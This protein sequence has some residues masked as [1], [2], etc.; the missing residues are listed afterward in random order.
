[1][2]PHVLV[3]LPILGIAD[4]LLLR[5]R[6]GWLFWIR[7]CVFEVGT[8]FGAEGLTRVVCDPSPTQVNSALGT[9]LH[10]TDGRVTM[11]H[12]IGHG[13]LAWIG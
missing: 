3:L 8:V 2:L 10:L 12:A 9:G 4:V 13:R 1:L 6:R 11:G 5:A 7:A